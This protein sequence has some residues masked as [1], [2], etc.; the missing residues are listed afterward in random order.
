MM[1]MMIKLLIAQHNA[2]RI[3]PRI[4]AIL[5]SHSDIAHIGA[6][7]YLV[8]KLGCRAQIFATLPVCKMAQMF[9]YDTFQ[10]YSNVSDTNET[11]CWDLDDVDMAF[12]SHMIELKYSQRYKFKN[13]IVIAAFAAGRSLGGSVWRISK[14]TDEIV[15]AVDYN[16]RKERHLNG[17]MLGDTESSGSVFGRPSLLITDAYNALNLT[18]SKAQDSVIIDHIVSALRQDGNVLL[19]TDSA[20]RVFELMI[21][22][23]QYWRSHRNMQGYGLAFLSNMSEQTVEFASHQ[24]EWMSDA[25]MRNF[26]EKRESP[27]QFRNLRLCH[28]IEELSRLPSPMVVLTTS[29][30]LEIGFARDLFARWSPHPNNLVLFTDRSFANSLSRTLITQYAGETDHGA[31]TLSSPRTLSLKMRRRVPLE[32]L[33]LEEYLKKKRAMEEA[34]KKRKREEEQKKNVIEIR[35]A[36][37]LDDEDAMMT[38]VEHGA[39]VTMSAGDLASHP[40]LFL[41]HNMRYFSQHLMFPCI[42]RAPQFDEYGMKI[43]MEELRKRSLQIYEEQKAELRLEN[44]MRRPGGGAMGVAGREDMMDDEDVEE[45]IPTKLVEETVDINV[46]CR[47]AY[48]DFEGRSN[49]RSVRN[50]LQQINARK[51]VIIHGDPESTNALVQFCNEK[52]FAEQVEAPQIG[53]TVDV[54]VD[55]NMFKVRLQEELLAQLEFVKHAAFDLAYLD[56]EYQIDETA[57]DIYQQQQQQNYP[58]KGPMPT[59]SLAKTQID[60]NALSMQDGLSK[61]GHKTLLVGDVRLNQFKD[62]LLQ[63]G[64]RADFQSGT[65]YCNN[66]VALRKD[67]TTGQIVMHGVL[68][69]DYFRIRQLLYSQYQ[70]L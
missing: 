37:D 40:R 19:P 13:G 54:T 62:L 49:G 16:H 21:V 46:V 30:S 15:Y 31:A 2:H 8:S 32:G 64:F 27:F 65:L 50:I 68:G 26:D 47:M 14:E 48:V 38:N 11:L 70:T 6:L 39:S 55:T 3:A 42:E 17:T 7:P 34:E 20:A 22:L 1:M 63:H 25:V 59:V 69:Q 67:A 52:K 66:S 9:M 41:P 56:G 51:I 23:D 43:D 61:K 24:L 44:N 53:E 35:D 18:P 60:E 28:S 4:D 36:E 12:D 58:Q 5:L 57:M 29:H 10:S 45:E 33:E